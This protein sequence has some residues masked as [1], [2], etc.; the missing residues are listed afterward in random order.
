[1]SFL[2]LPKGVLPLFC[3]CLWGCG[4]PTAEPF[5]APFEGDP[6]YI[7]TFNTPDGESCARDGDCISGDCITTRGWTDGHC[8]TRG[9][10][11][12]TDCPGSNSICVGH[13]YEGAICTTACDP[14]PV[15][16]CRSGYRCEEISPTEGWCAPENETLPRGQAS[17][18]VAQCETTVGG[19]ATF[20][21]EIGPETTS[22][23]LVPHVVGGSSWVQPLRIRAPSQEI[24]FGRENRFQLNPFSFSGL[25]P[26][27]IPGNPSFQHQLE[28]GSHTIEVRSGA[29]EVCLWLFE[30]ADEPQVIDVNIY[31]V[32]LQNRGI[33]SVTAPTD[34]NF[35]RVLEETNSILAEAGVQL[36]RVRFREFD[37]ATNQAYQVMRSEQDVFQ[38]LSN[39]EPPGS[40]AEAAL[41]INVVIVAAFTF[42][43]LG[44]SMGIP[45]AVGIHGEWYSGVV[46]SGQFIG[47]SGNTGNR[48][49]AVTFAHEV[50]HF[51]GLPHTSEQSGDRFDHFEDTPQCSNYDQ[52]RPWRCPD[53]GYL[54]FPL[55]DADNR[56]ISDGQAFVI[57]ANPLT[58]A[59][60]LPEQYDENGQEFLVP[61]ESPH[62]EES[63]E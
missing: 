3:L 63:A 35:R 51:L 30:S 45:G 61:E 28:A 10:T 52:R 55:A 5:A 41:S 39:T 40:S 12:S 13:G 36:G 24:N 15:N 22:Y 59:P 8:T 50:G 9:C 34:R 17:P 44:I 18:F 19:I 31:L 56:L 62:P 42:G 29:T 7:A 27:I 33:N 14:G 60:I 54:M 58:K 48:L 11:V 37:R 1:M 6:P 38:V 32:G 16:Q 4:S 21:Y 53:W 46:M 20:T 25:N 26:L 43:P 2:R 23:M 47:T 57:Q 49:T